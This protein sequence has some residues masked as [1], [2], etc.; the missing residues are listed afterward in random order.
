MI[1]DDNGK[2]S[3]IFF[4]LQ[5]YLKPEISIEIG[6]HAA[7]FSIGMKER[8]DTK[9]IAFEASE[10]IFNN[11]KDKI[12][13]NGVDYINAAIS[14]FDGT[15]FFYVHEDEYHGNNSTLI[16]KD[17]PIKNR[18]LVN[19][20]KLDSYLLNR[21]FSSMCLW[22]D[23]EGANKQVLQGSIESLK[24]TNSIFIETED[25]EYWEDQWLTGDVVEFLNS[26]GFIQVAS[27]KVY[28][29]QQNIIFIRKSIYPNFAKLLFKY[30][31]TIGL[32]RFVTVRR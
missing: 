4:N 17:A 12:F 30:Q 6:A 25:L 1:I 14:D 20:Y 31:I 32:L 7:E 3:N 18:T 10:L 23:V 27:E 28:D 15:M 24:K 19:C 16:R 5:K 29:A 11:F 26:Q 13:S 9:P 21:D 22:I 8:L 2:L